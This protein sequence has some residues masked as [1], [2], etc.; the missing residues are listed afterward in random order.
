MTTEY[1]K[2]VKKKLIDMD[3]SQE[4]LM[5][6][7]TKRTGLFMDR[8]YM[9]KIYRGKNNPPKIIAA[10]NEILELEV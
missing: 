5:E 7:I 10:I 4:W 2:T 8:S 3:K 1:G 6:Q 9:S